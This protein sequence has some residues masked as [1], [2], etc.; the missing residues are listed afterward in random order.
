MVDR[1]HIVAV[2]FVVILILGGVQIIDPSLEEN[3]MHKVN[4]TDSAPDLAYDAVKQLRDVDYTYVVRR[5]ERNTSSGTTTSR[6]IIEMRVENSKEKYFLINNISD[7]KP[8]F[9]YGNE[10]MGWAK[11][12]LSDDIE[13]NKEG[14]WRPLSSKYEPEVH[15][16][17]SPAELN[18]TDFQI[19]EE[20]DEYILIHSSDSDQILNVIGGTIYLGVSPDDSAEMTITVDKK[21]K[22]ISNLFV[23][24][25]ESTRPIVYSYN[26]T[27]VDYGETRVKRPEGI[28]YTLGEFVKDLL[29]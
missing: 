29:E 24:A 13:S 12:E 14:G 10:L 1:I 19:I 18:E 21:Q 9:R 5:T 17:L 15:N 8:V 3:R 27:F 28:S 20:T 6:K 22:R 4:V 2:L 25:E 7:K 26:I 16:P 11:S 23:Q